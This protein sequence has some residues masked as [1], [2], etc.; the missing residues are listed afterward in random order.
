MPRLAALPVRNRRRR[1]RRTRAAGY[2]RVMARIGVPSRLT[3]I[4]AWHSPHVPY[5]YSNVVGPG[6]GTVSMPAYV[7]LGG[8]HS[9]GGIAP[10]NSGHGG[11]SSS[12]CQMAELGGVPH[13]VKVSARW[14]S[15]LGSVPD[16]ASNDLAPPG[17]VGVVA[18]QTLGRPTRAT[19]HPLSAGPSVRAVPA[20]LAARARCSRGAARSLA[21]RD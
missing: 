6:S 9:S 14:W 8:P 19:A 5:R 17:G 13:L 20:V 18:V 3:R 21:S 2:R 12:A 16:R 7:P 11:V 15:P 10:P 1:P 4:I